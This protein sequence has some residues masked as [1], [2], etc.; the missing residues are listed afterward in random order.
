MTIGC[1]ASFILV[2]IVL[3]S[4]YF[5]RAT[6]P[7]FGYRCNFPTAAP[8]QGD[9]HSPFPQ[10]TLPPNATTKTLATLTDNSISNPEAMH[11][12]FPAFQKAFLTDNVVQ[13]FYMPDGQLNLLW[14]K[15]PK[16]F[17]IA[18]NAAYNQTGIGQVGYWANMIYQP[19]FPYSDNKDVKIV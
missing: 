10:Y 9:I 7:K 18:C 11:V 5:S 3:L 17:L 19:G 1:A 4:L 12:Y 8:V 13:P 2:V 15:N 14:N 6:C 16:L